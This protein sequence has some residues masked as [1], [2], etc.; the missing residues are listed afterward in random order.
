MIVRIVRVVASGR[1]T[2][3]CRHYPWPERVLALKISR[4]GI[5]QDT[6]RSFNSR[7]GLE[8]LE[9]KKLRALETENA[10]AEEFLAGQMLNDAILRHILGPAQ[11]PCPSLATAMWPANFC[12]FG[13]EVPVLPKSLRNMA[14][15]AHLRGFEPLASAFGGQRSIQLS[16][17]CLGR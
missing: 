2:E 5:S 7:C 1:K 3:A 10:K 4:E 17:R 8:L 11:D 12:Q 13:A 16:Y 6:F 9:A 15:V 14:M